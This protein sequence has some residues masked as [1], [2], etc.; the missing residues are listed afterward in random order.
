MNKLFLIMVFATT[1]FATGC[2]TVAGAG[3]DITS[4]AEYV[5]DKIGGSK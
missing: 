4:G 2:S 1:A 5:R 3:K